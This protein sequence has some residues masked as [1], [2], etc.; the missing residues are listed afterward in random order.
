MLRGM[1]GAVTDPG[2][3]VFTEMMRNIGVDMGD[4]PYNDYETLRVVNACPFR[5]PRP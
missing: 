2:A 1:W 3:S 4:S 5:N